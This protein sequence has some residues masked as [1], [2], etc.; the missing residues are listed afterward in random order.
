MGVVLAEERITEILAA[1]EP[2]LSPYIA[3]DGT[4][5]FGTS[6]HVVTGTRP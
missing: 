2:A 5:S 3:G 6:A 4:V 1:A